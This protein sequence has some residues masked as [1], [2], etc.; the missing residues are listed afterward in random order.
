M[1]VRSL[2]ELGLLQVLYK[3]TADMQADALA[4]FMPAKTLHRQ[5]SLMVCVPSVRPTSQEACATRP[6]S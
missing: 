5:R 1:G 4:K 3:A 2:I 6:Y